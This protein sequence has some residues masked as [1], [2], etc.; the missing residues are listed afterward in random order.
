M[1]PAVGIDLG[2]TNTVAA[3]QT[4]STGPRLVSIPQPRDL[5]NSVE[6][7]DHIKSAVLFE[8][9]TSAV[10]G[11][12]AAR[13][14]DAI[15]SV[16]SHMGTRWRRRIRSLEDFVTAPYVSAHVLRPVVETLTSEFPEWDRTAIV[17]VPA[18][19]NTEQRSD[20]LEAA[21]LAGLSSVRLL[22]EPTAAFYY[23][24]DQSRPFF[25]GGQQQTVLVF[26]FGGGTLDVAVIQIDAVADR[27]LI[28]TIGRSRYNNL[29]GDDVD[30]DLG[31]FF[32]ARWLDET[33]MTESSIPQPLRARLAQLFITKAS[34]YK[35][36]VEEYLRQGLTP[37][38]F[39]ID[40]EVTDGSATLRVTLSELLGEEQYDALSSAYFSAESP[41]NVFRPIAQA[42]DVA[43]EI[44]S[45]FRKGAIDLVL[46]TGGASR[47][48]RVEAA[49]R[50]YFPNAQ[51]YEINYEDACNTVALGAAS[52]RFDE[53]R[54]ATEVL[55]KQRL[56]E[57]I[58]TRPE[59]SST[60]IPV[61]PLTAEPSDEFVPVN[62]RFKTHRQ[63]VTL[64]I[65]LFRG[66]GPSDHNIAPMG[67]LRL[68]LPKVLDQGTPYSILYRL[69]QDKTIQLK[70]RFDT[71]PVIERIGQ[72]DFSARERRDNASSQLVQVNR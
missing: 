7:Q 71:S 11:A 59:H 43:Q 67:Q 63:S 49:L 41:L 47:M 72:F 48:R 23:Y 60:Y 2:T 42:L 33:G 52:C 8:S 27:V 44:K 66:G 5:R 46:Y 14:L 31:A 3:V 22:D 28:D 54:R 36:E 30:L 29:G 15:R 62:H 69:T 65:P 35:E 70:V 20:T 68:M 12:F 50:S 4:D 34:H 56:L 26:D 51:C 57:S 32:M 55:M 39:A 21:R 18:S 37:N 17:T 16:K 10:V 38:E 40:E 61:V 19:F 45:D 1:N 64:R 6:R 13:R 24:F 25:Q 53:Q 58:M 9:R